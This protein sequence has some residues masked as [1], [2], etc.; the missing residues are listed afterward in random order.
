MQLCYCLISK[1]TNILQWHQS[2]YEFALPGGPH[3]PHEVYVESSQPSEH[4]RYCVTSHYTQLDTPSAASTVCTRRCIRE[5]L[6]TLQTAAAASIDVDTAAA[7]AS[8][9]MGDCRYVRNPTRHCTSPA[10]RTDTLLLPH[11]YQDISYE[12]DDSKCTIY[13]NF[14]KYEW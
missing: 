4:R 8:V 10:S 1:L 9:A 13:Y 2:P 11:Q 6:W 7:A 5:T 12:F 3:R 14:K